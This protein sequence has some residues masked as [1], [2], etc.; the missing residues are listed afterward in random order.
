MTSCIPRVSPIEYQSVVRIHHLHNKVDALSLLN[1][2]QPL[3]IIVMATKKGDLIRGKRGDNIYYVVDGKQR[4]RSVAAH[5]ANPNTNK[6][7]KQRNGFGDISTL[8]SHMMEPLNLGLHYMALRKHSKPYLYFR[9]INKGCFTPDR[10]IDYPR[11]I[12]SYGSVARVEITSVK[13]QTIKRSGN[14]AITITFDPCFNY[15]DADPDDEFYLYAYCPTLGAGTLFPPVLR[16]S[17]TI[18]VTI[19]REWFQN[20]D[21]IPVADQPN[22]D[23]LTHPSNNTIH[24]YAFLR[25]PGPKPTTPESE[26]T[27]AKTHRGHTSPTIYIPLP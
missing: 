1:N 24:L 23:A 26:K 9:S 21:P 27:Y 19:P 17:G 3:T 18:T 14:Q 10:Q 6:Q 8:S 4:V 11:I 12:L 16:K 2:K 5:V 15:G 7:Q 13:T 20:V 22:T 25:F